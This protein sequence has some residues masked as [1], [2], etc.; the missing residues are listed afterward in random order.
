VLHVVFVPTAPEVINDV[1]PYYEV[2]TGNGFSMVSIG[3]IA[4]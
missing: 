3:A 1:A 2:G 4:T